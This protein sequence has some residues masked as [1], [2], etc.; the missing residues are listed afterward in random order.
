[1]RLWTLD[2]WRG[3]AVILMIIFHFVYDLRE[4]YGVPADYQ[5]GF[6]YW[7]G[8]LS[9]VSFILIAGCSSRFSRS[10]LRHGVQVLLWGLVITAVTA[11]V[12]PAGF[13]R[14]GILHLL[15]V[16]LLTTPLLQRLSALPL[17]LLTV[18]AFI[19][20]LYPDWSTVSGLLRF[21]GLFPIPL[22]TV[23]YYPFFPWYGLFVSGSALGRILLP[24]LAATT[25]P[26]G[27]RPVCYL[28]RHSLL[29]YLLH[30]PLLLAPYYLQHWL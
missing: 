25:A 22:N 14:F 28:G 10:A 29:L 5:S 30:Q 19:I 4:F 8:R 24:L 1:M 16:S 17:C 23:D 12:I 27:W 15:G 7:T 13:I 2:A 18:L 6:C 11:T 20:G 26:A 21:P 3:S 9:A